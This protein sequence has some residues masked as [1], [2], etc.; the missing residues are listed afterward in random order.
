M[1]PAS[2]L[3]LRRVALGLS[4]QDVADQIGVTRPQVSR[5]ESGVAVPDVNEAMAIARVLACEIG[6]LW[7]VAS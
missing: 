3:R 5:F 1:Q 2:P 4:Q 6:D 7:E